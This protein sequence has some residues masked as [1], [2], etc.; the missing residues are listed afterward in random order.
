MKRRRTPKQ[1]RGKVSN[2]YQREPNSNVAARLKRQAD[3]RSQDRQLELRREASMRRT[4]DMLVEGLMPL[5]MAKSRRVNIPIERALNI[6][7][8]EDEG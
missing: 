6:G 7:E 3:Q 8:N 5:L 4:N 2:P 1:P